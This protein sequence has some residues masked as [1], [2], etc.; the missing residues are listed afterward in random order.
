MFGSSESYRSIQR[1]KVVEVQPVVPDGHRL[2]RRQIANL[3]QQLVLS[4]FQFL[5]KRHALGALASGLVSVFAA[6]SAAY[7]F[8]ICFERHNYYLT[9]YNLNG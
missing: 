1:V 6:Q 9:N 3:K 5:F 2:R 7:V 4:E 8:L